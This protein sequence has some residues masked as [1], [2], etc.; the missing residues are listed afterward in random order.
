MLVLGR[1]VFFCFFIVVL[2]VLL[3]KMDI[4]LVGKGECFGIIS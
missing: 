1:E 4:V 3:I 2:C